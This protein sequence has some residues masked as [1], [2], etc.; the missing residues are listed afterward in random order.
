MVVK[1][2][3]KLFCSSVGKKHIFV[4]LL[5]LVVRMASGIR[6]VWIALPLLHLP[7]AQVG[8]RV[9]PVVQVARPVVLGLPLVVALGHRVQDLQGDL[10]RLVLQVGQDLRGEVHL[11]HHLGGLVHLVLRPHRRHPVRQVLVHLVLR[12][13]HPVRLLVPLVHHLGGDVKHA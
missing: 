4:A 2:V 6:T 3:M 8:H 10:D 5:I 11:D 1:F 13:H 7:V 12:L 9:V